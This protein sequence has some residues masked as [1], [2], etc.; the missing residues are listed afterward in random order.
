[1]QSGLERYVVFEERI[2]IAEELHDRMGPHLFGIACAVH[3]LE[4]DWGGT[5]EAQKLEQLR[6][7]KKAIASA[8][9][10]LRM[11][12]HGLSLSEKGGASW[13]GS[14]ESLL[15]SQAKLNGV[16]IRF[17]APDFD[18]RLTVH[19]QKVLYRIIAEAVGN[20]IRHGASSKVDVKL[21]LRRNAVTL[22]IA[23][24]GSGF[25]VTSRQ[26]SKQDSGF[27]LGN[28]KVLAAS[29]GGN[30]QIDSVIGGGTRIVVRLPLDDANEEPLQTMKK[31]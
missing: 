20:A 4:Q 14:V 21:T 23:D 22:R 27:G 26:P 31:G 1:M 3:S 18:R 7:I 12:I 6:E 16:R 25:D 29:L 10:E 28:M 19:H 9:R 17:R 8:S 30:L 2:R 11:A 24:N 15:A 13:I 5:S